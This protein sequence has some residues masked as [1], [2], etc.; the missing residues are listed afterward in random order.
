MAIK[1]TATADRLVGLAEYFSAMKPGDK[2]G[3]QDIMD[4][5]GLKPGSW[6]SFKKIL[7]TYIAVQ[8]GNR[9]ER[10]FKR[11]GKMTL[12]SYK[13]VAVGTQLPDKDITD[14]LVEQEPIEQDAIP[15]SVPE[16]DGT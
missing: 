7:D 15:T 3:Q 12:T 2:V 16:Q 4:K 1:R 10:N 13:V 14:E 9:I 6:K 5:L 8:A 11:F